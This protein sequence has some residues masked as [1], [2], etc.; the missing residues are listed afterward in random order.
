MTLSLEEELDKRNFHE[1]TE[2]FAGSLCRNIM[3]EYDKSTDGRLSH[4][5]ICFRNQDKT[6]EIDSFFSDVLENVILFLDM[7]DSMTISFDEKTKMDM[8]HKIVHFT[9]LKSLKKI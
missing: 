1:N 3:L 7:V 6:E 2:R 5:V 9:T 8:A 4:V